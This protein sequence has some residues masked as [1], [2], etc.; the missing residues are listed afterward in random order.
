MSSTGLKLYAERLDKIIYCIFIE[1]VGKNFTKNVVETGLKPF[2]QD[3]KEN[4]LS[5]NY[6]KF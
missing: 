3:R 1:K 4:E 5:K 6:S 2:E